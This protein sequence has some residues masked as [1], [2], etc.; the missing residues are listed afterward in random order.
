MYICARMITVMV[1]FPSKY[2]T[3]EHNAKRE[4]TYTKV[5]E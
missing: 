2:Y 3:P 4:H 1:D 5:L